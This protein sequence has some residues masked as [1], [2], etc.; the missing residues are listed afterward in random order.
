MTD[1]HQGEERAAMSMSSVRHLEFEHLSSLGCWG[2]VRSGECVNSDNINLI[3]W[4]EVENVP[5]SSGSSSGSM[6]LPQD[7]LGRQRIY[8]I[9]GQSGH[10]SKTGN[11]GA[12]KI[13]SC[14]EDRSSCT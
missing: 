10:N 14:R 1:R 6:T 5:I 4:G 8:F 12:K 13:K 9:S 3:R 7:I 2:A 11:E